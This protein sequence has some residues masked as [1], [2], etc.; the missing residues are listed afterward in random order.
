MR[1]GAPVFIHTDDADDPDELARHHAE[2]G[3]RAARDHILAVAARVGVEAT[4]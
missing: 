2:K 3:C 1:P 4:Q